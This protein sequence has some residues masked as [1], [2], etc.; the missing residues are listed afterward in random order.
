MTT[1][2]EK[3]KLAD[4]LALVEQ[5]ADCG[6]NSCMFAAPR[7]RGMS[8]NGGCRCL[9]RPFVGAALVALVRAVRAEVNREPKASKP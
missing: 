2:P 7:R 3:S 6:D 9:Q 8:T 5:Y 4:A 1:E